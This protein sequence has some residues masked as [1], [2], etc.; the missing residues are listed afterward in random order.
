MIQSSVPFQL[1][2]LLL[3]HFS[4]STEVMLASLKFPSQRFSAIGVLCPVLV[5][6]NRLLQIFPQLSPH[7]IYIFSQM[8]TS[9]WSLPSISYLKLYQVSPTQQELLSPLWFVSLQSTYRLRIN[10]TTY[11]TFS[12]CLFLWLFWYISYCISST[13]YIWNKTFL[14]ICLFSII[15]A[16]ATDMH[17]D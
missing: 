6:C 5:H 12:L 17:S 10:Y 13:K 15:S 8:L 3:F 4:F 1:F 11:F 16:K 14:L 7:I 2:L 9:Q